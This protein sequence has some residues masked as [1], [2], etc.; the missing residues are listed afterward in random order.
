MNKSKIQ[1]EEPKMSKLMGR[2]IR[3]RER[4]AGMPNDATFELVEVEVAEPKDGEI[5]VRNIW[6]SVDPYMRG[7]MRDIESYVPP[8]QVG[9]TLE[10]GAIG[11]VMR[12]NNPNFAEGDYVSSMFGWREY[13][14]SNGKGVTKVDP[15]AAPLQAY[16]GVLGMPGLTAYAG[17]LEVGKPKAGETVFV[18]AAAGAVGSVVCQI[19]KAKGCRVAG[20]AGSD[21]KVRWLRE[22]AGIDAAF[23]YKTEA[24]L[25]AAMK[26]A[27]PEGIDIYFDNVGGKHLETALLL[28]KSFGRIPVCGMI[29]Q[30]NAFAPAPGPSTLINV[31]PK[32]LRLEG[33]IVTDHIKLMPQFFA[34]MGGWIK[35]GK[36][37][38]QETVHEG[39][40]EAPAA[41]LGLFQ[42][43]NIGK[44]LVKVGPDL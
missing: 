8:F 13:W 18:S 16:L 43:E 42:G 31:I 2:E 22:E 39:L 9:A 10:G 23:N 35:A 4:P 37:K 1:L 6:M 41:F 11:R 24:N 28:M 5:Q 30:Y 26:K 12:S 15:K 17:L 44:M 33:F 34:D 7:R 3:L 27:C 20:S 14:V 29:E 38:W 21:E 25:A 36:M 19:S 32:R 40:E